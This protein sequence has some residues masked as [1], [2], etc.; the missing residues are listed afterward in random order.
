MDLDV[1]AVAGTENSKPSNR[2]SNRTSAEQVEEVEKQR[3]KIVEIYQRIK[4][5]G[6]K[7]AE[8]REKVLPQIL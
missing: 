7:A 4:Q 6:V 1:K 5:L 8:E 3:A 2:L